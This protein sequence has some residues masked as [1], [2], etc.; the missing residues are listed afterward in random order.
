MITEE[1]LAANGHQKGLADEVLTAPKVEAVGSYRQIL[2]RKIANRQATVGVVGLGYVGLPLATGFAEAGFP[3]VGIDLSETRVETLRSGR[4]Y[5]GDIPSEQIARLISPDDVSPNGSLT[6]GSL[7]V[8]AGFEPLSQVDAVIV[9][10]PTPL[11]DDHRPDV[12]HIV[13]VADQ[14]GRRLRRGTLVLL[15]S[16]TY[17]GTT[18]EILL[19]R[20][21]KGGDGQDGAERVAGKDFFLAFSPER[22]DPG[23]RD[24]S[25]RT[26]PKVV[27]GTTPACL[28]VATALYGCAIDKV[29]PVS[30][31]QVAETVKL[32]E[33]TFRALNIGL[34]NE[35]AIMCDR[36]GID[37]WEV[38]EAART[39]PFGFMPFYP[40]PGIGGHCIPLDPEYLAWKLRGVNYHAR[41]IE[42][43]EEI[44]SAMPSYVVG[45]V[46]DALNEETKALKGARILVI[47]M[48]YKANV[49]DARESPSLEIVRL[50][51]DKGARVTY[52]DPYVPYVDVGAAKL[53]SV[54]LD[55]DVIA[56]SDCVLIVTAHD[57]CNWPLVLRHST[58]VVD[59]R[60]VTRGLEPYSARVVRL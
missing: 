30:T 7:H 5:I 23:R 6:P 22:I 18:E 26:T 51:L 59:T 50:L 37:V 45:K 41:T 31:T 43:A 4:S 39:K 14:L 35:M 33:N 34:A 2:L 58:L 10:V 49:A 1:R 53:S 54:E 56:R 36:L 47:G 60:N 38:I 27:G 25:L 12:S 3:V 52:H 21:Q 29:V 17:P 57:A 40:G 15:E 20:L 32:L 55:K 46:V 19:P 16:T 24:Y 28:E 44:N 8:S 48:A 9:C 13:A 11:T 42:L